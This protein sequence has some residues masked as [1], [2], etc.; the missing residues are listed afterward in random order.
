M[1]DN[2]APSNRDGVSS[3]SGNS[4]EP[5]DRHKERLYFEHLGD[6]FD[7]LMDEYDVERRLELVFSVLLAGVK[8]GDTEVLEVGCGTGR[9]SQKIVD[10]GAK[11]TVLDVGTNLVTRVTKSCSCEGI[12]AD[13]LFLPFSSESF[14]MVISSECIEH[15]ADP[16][17]AIQEMSRICRV[18]GTVCLTSPNRLWY[19]ILIAAQRLGLREFSGTENWIFPRAAERSLR[20][21]GLGALRLNGCHLWPFQVRFSRRLLRILDGYGKWLFPLMINFGVVGRKETREQIGS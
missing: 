19:P 21:S 6:R 9:F 17:R 10:S 14:D 4:A 13:A 3:V 8:L 1:I 15:T 18:G 16:I 2:G 20:D 12:V 11:L 5:S 7:E